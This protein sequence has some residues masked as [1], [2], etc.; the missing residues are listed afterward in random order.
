QSA[1]SLS[2]RGPFPKQSPHFH[3]GN[4]VA[5]V[6]RYGMSKKVKRVIARVFSEAI[7]RTPQKGLLREKTPSQ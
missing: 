5:A 6:L 3:K 4:L 2:L 7:S 1:W